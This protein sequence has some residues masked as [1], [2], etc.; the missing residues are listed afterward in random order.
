MYVWTNMPVTKLHLKLCMVYYKK[1][2]ALA[3][4]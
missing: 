1:M 3:S 4:D 2:C